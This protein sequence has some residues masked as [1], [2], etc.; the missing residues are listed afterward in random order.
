MRHHKRFLGFESLEPRH[1]F[2]V[3]FDTPQIVPTPANEFVGV[4]KHTSPGSTAPC[5]GT[6]ISNRHVLT[7]G[8]CLDSLG[9]EIREVTFNTPSR[10][11]VYSNQIPGMTCG[12]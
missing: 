10:P 11:L 12:T 7:A 2:V 1:M 6:L 9:N 5:S 8:H 4:A 3:M